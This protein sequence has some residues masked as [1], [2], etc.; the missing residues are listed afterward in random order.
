MPEHVYDIP[1]VALRPGRRLRVA[2]G[3]LV[4]LALW[5][6][7]RVI[8]LDRELHSHAGEALLWSALFLVA[9][10]QFV[11]AWFDKPFVVTPSQQDKLDRLVVTVNVPVWNEDHAI[12]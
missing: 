8:S 11:I 6:G 5:G 4:V 9:A 10:Q 2:C 1:D 7:Y 3:I 12:L